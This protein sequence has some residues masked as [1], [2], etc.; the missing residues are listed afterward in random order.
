MMKAEAKAMFDGLHIFEMAN[1]HQGDVD[2]GIAI[3]DAAA[4]LKQRHGVTAAVKLQFRELDSFIHPAAKGRSDIKHIGRFESTRLDAEDFRTLL[5]AIRKRGLVSVVTPFD[6][7]SVEL[8]KALGVDIIKV[9]SCSA[10]DWPLLEA[11]AA[12]G[13]PVIASTGGLSIYQI[14]NLVTFLTKRV[15][16]LAVMHCVSMYPTPPEQHHMDFMTRMAKR[17]PY[18][19]VGYSGHE[20]PDN[21]DVVTVAIAKGARLLERHFGVPT[22]TI[23]LNGYSMNP[24]QAD[25]W[26]A[27]ATRAR[28]ICGAGGEKP[29]SEA[30]ARSLL[31][32]QRGVFA[33]RPLQK[34]EAIGRGDVYYAMPCEP[35]QLTSGQFG[36]YRTH[37]VAS[38]DYGAD[39]AVFE[40]HQNDGLSRLRGILHDAKGQLYE[41]GIALGDD[42][43]IEVSH[44]Y[45]LERCR[46][47]G[48][49]L[50]NS[51]NR[52]EYCNKFLIMLPGQRHPHHKHEKKEETFHVLWGD[53][54]VDL[55]GDI[56]HLEAGDKL[57]VERGQL[58]AFRSETGCIFAEVSTKSI[59]S[60]SYYA[61]AAIAAMDPLE[62]KTI[63]EGW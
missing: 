13:R 15:K 47:V 28:A 11:I 6:E 52:D 23:T 57:L 42:I 37:Y 30:E 3:I 43:T 63:V 49:V 22:D 17:Y 20:P 53:L 5:T 32:L 18:V 10:T 1:N 2:H 45:G 62:R 19:A 48:C 55:D 7:P 16:A 27:A 14:D 24:A 54:E 35:G 38:R 31:E 29:V 50:V 46:E 9:A 26:L 59:R 60:D 33:K 61:D 39:E 56:I 34:G 12:A 4:E 51:I 36:Q 40:V 58:H 41:A 25:A 8:C 21:T 44:H